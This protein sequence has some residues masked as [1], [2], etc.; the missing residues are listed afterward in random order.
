MHR[1]VNAESL[2]EIVLYPRRTVRPSQLQR[3]HAR[4]YQHLLITTVLLIIDDRLYDE[5]TRTKNRRGGAAAA[6]DFVTC[7]RARCTV[8]ARADHLTMPITWRARPVLRKISGMTALHAV[9]TPTGASLRPGELEDAL[10]MPP[11]YGVDH[12][13]NVRG[14]LGTEVER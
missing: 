13:R 4:W 1:S 14:I 2:G 9:P 8:T 5:V 6:P 10:T 3:K 11:R 7:D 12:G